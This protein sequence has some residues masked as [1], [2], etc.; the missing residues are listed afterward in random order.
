MGDSWRI[1]YPADFIAAV[2]R[3]YPENTK[4][5]Y[6]LS[7]GHEIVGRIL[8]DNCYYW[9]PVSDVLR[10]TSL[11]EIQA[12]ARALQEKIALYT[13]WQQLAIASQQTISE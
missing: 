10:A 12:E 1:N 8:N 13:W 6:W 4:L 11:A 9:I 3:T 7:E 5:H 2:K